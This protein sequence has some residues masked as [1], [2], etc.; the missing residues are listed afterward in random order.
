MKRLLPLFALGILVLS[1]ETI[2]AQKMAQATGEMTV[3]YIDVGQGDAILIEFPK[4]AIMIDAGG[5]DTGDTRFRDHL[6][7]RLNEL[8]KRRG[9]SERVIDAIIITHPHLDHTSYLPD[10]L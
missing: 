4:A 9:E 2:Q 7:E 10:I 3:H 1:S 5:E 6:L 8:F